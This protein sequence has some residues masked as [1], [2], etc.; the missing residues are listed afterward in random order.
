MLPREHRTEEHRAALEQKICTMLRTG[1]PIFEETRIFEAER[2]D[3]ARIFHRQTVFPIKT[4]KGF[5][6]GSIAQDI[7]S[8]KREEDVV[9]E[10]EA[11]YRELADLLPQMVFEMD[12]DFQVTYANRH[13]FAT[14][15]YTEQ[16]LK[17]GVNAMSIIEPS[18]HGR[19]KE[20]IRKLLNGVALESQE[21]TCLR[22]DGSKIPVFIDTAPIYRNGNLTGFRGVIIDISA[23]KKMDAELRESEE[24]YRL[25]VENSDNVVYI[26]R[27]SQILFANRRATE[28]TG[29]TNDELI[30]M[31]I[32][33]LV[34]PDD[35]P[36]LQENAKLRISG[37]TPPP[38]FT[39][40]T[41]L[42]SGEERECEFFVNQILYQNQPAL[43]GILRDVSERKRAEEAM[44]ESEAKY[45]LLADHVHDVIWT[46][47][48]DMRLTYVSPS[49]TALRGLTPEEALRESLSDAL[50]PASYRTVMLM[51]EK[52]INEMRKSGTIQKY[53]TMELEFFRKDGSTVWTE[54]ILSP[55]FDRD[56][57]LFGVVGVIR[58]ITERKKAE[59]ALR[60]AN[61]QL[62]LLN[63]ITRHDILNN[64]SIAL[65]FLE[66]AEMKVEDPALARYLEKMESAITTIQSQIE[67]TRVYEDIGTHEPRWIDL[68][69]VMPRDHVPATI[70]LTA[71]VQG[72]GV[73]ADPMFEKVFFNLLDNAVRHGQRVTDIRVSYHLS[74][75]DLVV[76]WEDNGVGIAPDEKR[77]IFDLGFGKNTGFG[78][79][80]IRDILSLTGIMITETGEPGR[81]TRFEMTV[82]NGCYRLVGKQ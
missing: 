31:N 64:V 35:R 57:K 1:V 37:S 39:A 29:Y 11:K 58:D 17:D 32:W 59:E 12:P 36:H 81:G 25:V 63:G 14:L 41:I 45:R 40:R 24:K 7:T 5:R 77:L 48:M 6:F 51:R 78:L 67:F 30:S 66:I 80:L 20:D 19:V 79:F 71:D 4:D 68:T 15:G 60:R 27:G 34:H 72:V 47:D 46:A 13:A 55:T 49:V 53:Q 38:D 10:S 44:R 82:P 22:K 76:V 33:D 70:S 2:P 16:D 62:N 43:L 69:T 74:G 52:G 75:K 56:N 73:F 18:Q 54:T 50:T 61:R 21:Y 8:E 42:K 28:F 65:G 3:G 23:R 26:Y 9:R